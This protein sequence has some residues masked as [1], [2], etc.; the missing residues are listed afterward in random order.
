MLKVIMVSSLYNCKK[1]SR[2]YHEMK[3]RKTTE[4]TAQVQKEAKGRGEVM[5]VR[6]FG[7][8]ASTHKQPSSRGWG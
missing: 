4:K 7:Y 8:R 2:E 1:K 6:M 3:C 5:I